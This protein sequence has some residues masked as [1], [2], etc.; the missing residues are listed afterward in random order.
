MASTNGVI[1]SESMADIIANPVNIC[2][3]SVPPKSTAPTACLIIE[4][5]AIT[6][7]Q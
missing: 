7:N 5:N 6:S 1:F 4:R 3:G 2:F